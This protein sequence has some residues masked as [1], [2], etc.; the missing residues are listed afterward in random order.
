MIVRDYIIYAQRTKAALVQILLL[1]GNGIHFKLH[2]EMSILLLHLYVLHHNGYTYTPAKCVCRK[3]LLLNT[4][5]KQFQVEVIPE[6]A[7]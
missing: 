4:A 2:S 6:K 3:W 5:N 7:C 1:Q